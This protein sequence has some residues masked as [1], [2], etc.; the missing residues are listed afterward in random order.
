MSEAFVFIVGYHVDVSAAEADL[1]SARRAS[2]DL[3]DEPLDA[4]VIA[5]RDN[6]TAAIYKRSPAPEYGD[7]EMGVGFGLAAG[8]AVAVYPSIW[9]GAEPSTSEM[10]ARV[11]MT[12]EQ[13][14]NGLGRAA[15]REFGERLDAADAALIVAAPSEARESVRAAMHNAQ[16]ISIE[17]ASIESAP[18]RPPPT[19]GHGER[20][21]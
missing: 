10:S 9:L 2:R 17:E 5:K 15:L 13:V 18:D 3:R 20:R 16:S 11:G 19:I 1:I 14:G 12:A 21:V 6:A 4:V 7:D 8:L